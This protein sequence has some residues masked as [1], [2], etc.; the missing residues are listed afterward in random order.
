MSLTEYSDQV[1]L[2]GGCNRTQNLRFG[3]YTIKIGSYL[4]LRE[5]QIRLI[6]TDPEVKKKSRSTQLSMEF[7]L[8]KMLKCQQQLLSFFTLN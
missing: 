6:R 2:P 3:P 8:L 4:P 1:F 5:S 7:I